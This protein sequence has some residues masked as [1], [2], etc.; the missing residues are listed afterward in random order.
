MNKRVL[1][2][3]LA[4]VVGPAAFMLIVTTASPTSAAAEPGACGEPV[5]AATLHDQ[6]GRGLAHHGAE[7]AAPCD[8]VFFDPGSVRIRSDATTTL[9]R[10]VS[11]LLRNPTVR[12]RIEGHADRRETRRR[13][14]DLGRRRAEVVRSALAESGVP[15][16]RMEIASWGSDRPFDV[17]ETD[18]AHQNNRTTQTVI[19]T[20]EP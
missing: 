3:G 4:L 19:L 14:R 1:C 6:S 7:G 8:R 18:L 16:D 11:W 9:E 13:R 12:V 5:V 15:R 2:R 20:P 17:G 10:Q